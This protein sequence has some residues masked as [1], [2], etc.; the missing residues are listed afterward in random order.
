ML[1]L[2]QIDT[3]GP[4]D[5]ISSITADINGMNTARITTLESLTNISSTDSKYQLNFTTSGK[6]TLAK[7]KALAGKTALNSTSAIDYAANITGTIYSVL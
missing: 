2:N 4:Q 7:A 1:F 3:L 6:I 5:G